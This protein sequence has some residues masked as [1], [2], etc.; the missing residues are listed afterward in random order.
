MIYMCIYKYSA[1]GKRKRLHIWEAGMIR[2]FF[3]FYYY[4]IKA[5]TF[6]FMPTLIIIVWGPNTYTYARKK[7]I[8]WSK[9]LVV[10]YIV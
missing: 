9:Y 7:L 10:F 5:A 2:N 3:F 1:A 4:S 8:V 6:M